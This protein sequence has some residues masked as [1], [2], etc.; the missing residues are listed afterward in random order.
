MTTSIDLPADS[1]IRLRV[2]DSDNVTDVINL[3]VSDGQ[4]EFV[5]PNERS[6]AEAFAAT[7]VW[8]RAI[9]RGDEPVGFMMLSDDETTPRYYLWRF[10]IDQRFQRTGIGAVA[11]SLLHDYVRTR[12]GADRIFV[13]YVPEEGGP[14][15]FY[16]GLGYADTGTVHHGEVEAALELHTP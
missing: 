10:M 4:D 16:K 15:G 9:Y 11:M 5:A 12:P 1:V 14:E 6:L 8:V 7:H 2:V 13:A 3:S